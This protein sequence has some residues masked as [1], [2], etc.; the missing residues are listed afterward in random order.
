MAR[1]ETLPMT[2]HPGMILGKLRLESLL[3]RGG[4]ASVW[5]ATHIGLNSRMAVKVLDPKVLADDPQ[6]ERRFL[7]EAQLAAQTGLSR[8]GCCR[9]FKSMTGK[10]I[11]QYLEDY[12]VTQ[13]VRL[14]QEEAYSI[15]E[16]AYLVGFGNPGRF[17]AAF[18]RRMHCTP[19]QFRK[20]LCP[21]D[22]APPCSARNGE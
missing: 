3:G 8:E 2:P 13:G 15:T 9:L 16:V 18:A 1:H 4:M 12:R 10:T 7:R 5:L 21:S 19:S 14:L 17:S 6:Y 11:L 22:D 20:G